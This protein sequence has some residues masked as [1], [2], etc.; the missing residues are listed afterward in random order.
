MTSIEQELAQIEERLLVLE[1]EKNQLLNRKQLL[2]QERHSGLRT[3]QQTE[4]LSLEQKVALFSSLFKGR[5]DIFSL[6]W[7]NKQGRSGYSVA[8]ANEWKQ[9]I[10]NKPRIKCGDCSHRIFVPIDYSVIYDHL[11]GKHTV[12]LYPL[13]PDDDC[14]FLAVDFDKTDWQPS[15]LAFRQTC[16]DF[17]LPFIVERSRSGNGAHV[18]IFFEETV[19]ASD[20]R[21][22]GFALLDKAM[23]K[24][25]GLSFESYDRLFPN[26][27]TMPEGGFGNL[28]A[29]PLQNGPRQ[30]GNSVFVDEHF[31]PYPDQWAILQSLRK[32]SRREL[33]SLLDQLEDTGESEPELKPWE[34]SFPV[35]KDKIENC[36]ANVG[37][38]LANKIY[39]PIEGLPQALIARMKRVASFSNPV[40][41][42][43]QALRFSTNGI[44]RFICLATIEQ[45]YL[46]V[47]RG[48]YDDTVEILGQQDIELEIDD[49]RQTGKKLKA[50]KFKGELRADQKSAVKSLCKH[51]VG[52]LHAPTAFGKTVTAIGV[53]HKRKVNTLILVHSRQLLDQWKERLSM[54]LDNAEIGVI[55]GGKRKAT[56]IIDIATYQSLINR[57]DNT[58][59]QSVFEYGQ[60]IIDECHHISAPNYERLL[61]EIHSKYVFGVT[62]TP[63]RQDG[64]QPII[65]MHAGSIRHTVTSSKQSQFEQR[66]ITKTITSTPPENLL[67]SESRPHIAEVYRWLMENEERNRQIT[68][69]LVLAVNEGRNPILLT[70]RREHALLLS[71]LLSDRDVSHTILR[72]GMKVKERKDAMD[73]LNKTK[74]LIATGKYIGEGFDLPKLDTLFLALPIS[75]K[76]SLAQYAGRIHREAEGK[77]KVVIYDYVDS[78]LPMLQRMFQRRQ[79]GYSALGY[80]V[81]EAGA[82]QYIQGKLV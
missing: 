62:A 46:C 28:I 56:G 13:L 24:H 37:L 69:D 38:V 73:S 79:K 78:G 81:V 64:H 1:K 2:Q 43:T 26:Q 11:A 50:I 6:R 27:D 34:K 49:K 33:S 72:G 21:R 59:D 42:K 10:C 31:N 39:I 4:L 3:A 57:K 15:V 12:G 17:S 65:F 82:D 5:T 22:L 76:G 61:N 67:D 70:E 14:W 18:W 66:V 60:V 41:F 80:T 45:G 52:V 19:P 74:V 47:P 54:F 30:V 58:V 35:K 44:P 20:A 48:S 36:P 25:A 29:L 55:G 9:G 71:E 23:E 40:F 75:W 8:C 16:V 53:I 68:E 77:D 7:E 32:I 63:Q 51:D